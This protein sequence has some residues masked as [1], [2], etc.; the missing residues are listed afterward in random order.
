MLSRPRLAE[1]TCHLSMALMIAPGWAERAPLPGGSIHAMRFIEIACGGGTPG[2]R[3]TGASLLSAIRVK[4]LALAISMPDVSA[5]LPFD[6]L[7]RSSKLET[8]Q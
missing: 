8:T 4:A 7:Q 1:N 2:G 6:S 5:F 3:P